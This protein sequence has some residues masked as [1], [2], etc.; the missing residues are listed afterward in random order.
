M[1]IWRGIV[2]IGTGISILGVIFHLQGQSVIGPESSFMYAN[3]DWVS[4]G[5]QIVI[6]GII[7]S[8]AGMSIKFIKRI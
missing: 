4:F 8:A 6:L 5:I 3:P 2:I 1:N 7:I